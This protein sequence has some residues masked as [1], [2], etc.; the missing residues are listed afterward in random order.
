M[1]C[2]H[3]TARSAH[4]TEPGGV[5]D[6]FLILIFHFRFG[7]R[8][9]PDGG[10]LYDF[11]FPSFPLFFLLSTLPFIPK[12]GMHSSNVEDLHFNVLLLN[13]RVYEVPARSHHGPAHEC[14]LSRVVSTFGRITGAFVCLHTHERVRSERSARLVVCLKSTERC[15]FNAVMPACYNGRL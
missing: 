6:T 13:Y 5:G 11:M 1:K 9:S 10:G 2:S 12:C 8:L 14:I 4:S 7:K 3:F 15:I